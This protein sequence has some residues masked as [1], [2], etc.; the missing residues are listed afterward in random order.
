MQVPNHERLQLRQLKRRR[1][2]H[3]RNARSMW[4]YRVIIHPSQHALPLYI[5]RLHL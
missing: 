3:V 4:T 2:T 1:Q 5:K